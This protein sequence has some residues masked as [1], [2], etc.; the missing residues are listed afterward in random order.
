MTDTISNREKQERK[1]KEVMN[2]CLD[3]DGIKEGKLFFKSEFESFEGAPLQTANGHRHNTSCS[4]L[5]KLQKIEPTNTHTHKRTKKETR[6]KK[7]ILNKNRY[8][9]QSEIN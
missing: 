9:V 8:I 5:S 3:C 1:E 6:K 4:K 2:C 7:K